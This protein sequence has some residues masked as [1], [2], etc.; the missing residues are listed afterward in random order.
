MPSSSLEKINSIFRQ[1]PQIDKVLL[2]GSRA[3][4]NYRKGSDIDL[5]IESNSLDSTDLFSIET[6][7]DDLLLPWK[8]D[9]S[10]KNSIDNVALLEHINKMG[11][12]FFHN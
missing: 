12:V 11:I 9:L 2:Y 4:G 8:I 10:L 3:I 1:H 7:L 6:Q 5:C